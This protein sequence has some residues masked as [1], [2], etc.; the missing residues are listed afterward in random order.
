MWAFH[1]NNSF[2]NLTFINH[3]FNIDKKHFA[4]AVSD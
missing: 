4:N 3:G 2:N 1:G